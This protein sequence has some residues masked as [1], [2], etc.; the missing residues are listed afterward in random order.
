[1]PEDSTVFS[2]FIYKKTYSLL[3]TRPYYLS[4]PAIVSCSK[5]HIIQSPTQENIVKF[6]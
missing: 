6:S 4:F 1:M 5:N 2:R 3:S